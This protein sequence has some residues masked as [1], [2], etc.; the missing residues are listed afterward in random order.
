MAWMLDTNAVS[1]LLKGNTNIKAQLSRLA[2]SDIYISSVT[3][4]ELHYGL[5]KR[6]NNTAL[7]NLVFTL[8]STI[9]IAAW[10]NETAQ[11]YGNLRAKLEANGT[12]LGA[13]DTMIAAH[14]IQLG[15]TLVSNDK[16][17]AQVPTLMLEDWRE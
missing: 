5:A 14:A 3:A 6:P 7:G 12:S 13:L 16:A 8:L 15:F 1:D 4:G 9:N 11:H 10:T 2:P 17:F